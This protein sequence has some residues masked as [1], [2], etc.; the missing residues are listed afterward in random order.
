MF[1]KFLG[2]V[3]SPSRKE[4]VENIWRG[5]VLAKKKNNLEDNWK[6]LLSV[7]FKMGQFLPVGPVGNSVRLPIG[8]KGDTC[9]M[10]A[11]PG[12]PQYWAEFN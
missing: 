12:E 2:F 9:C 11:P 8:A 5:K 6:N 3:S 10:S 1:Y 4:F 7:I